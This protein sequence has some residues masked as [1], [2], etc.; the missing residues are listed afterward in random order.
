[1]LVEMIRLSWYAY[2]LPTTESL[3]S[4]LAQSCTQL[5]FSQTDTNATMVFPVAANAV[6]RRAGTIAQQQIQKRCMGGGHGPAPE[7]QGID[8]VVR[9]V[10]PGDHQCAFFQD[11]V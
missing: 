5:F 8:K 4:G 3:F 7:W 6:R 9:G 2:F 10:F 11:V 1:M